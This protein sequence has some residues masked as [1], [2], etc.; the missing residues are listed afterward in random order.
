MRDWR[1]KAVFVD[2]LSDDSEMGI[3]E[4]RS[5]SRHAEI[6]ILSPTAYAAGKPAVAGYDAE[7]ILVH[8]LMHVQLDEDCKDNALREQAVDT[9]AEALVQLRRRGEEA[10][11]D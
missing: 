8:E 10:Q 4:F 3:V 7:H 5:D 2:T 1:I 6:Q 11:A 9:I